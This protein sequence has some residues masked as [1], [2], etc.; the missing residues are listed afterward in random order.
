MAQ[1]CV[2]MLETQGQSIDV[3]LSEMSVEVGGYMLP[4]DAGRVR[5]RANF[6]LALDKCRGEK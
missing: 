2:A 5:E 6:L 3:T 4:E 1:A